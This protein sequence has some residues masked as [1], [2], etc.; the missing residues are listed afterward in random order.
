M[1][2]DRAAGARG[3]AASLATWAGYSGFEFV[4]GLADGTIRPPSMVETLP[5]TLL[6]PAEG[7][8]SLVAMPEARF[9]NLTNTITA[10]GS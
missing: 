6:P 4:A 7:K 2:M 3:G 10:V 5:F 1:T 8:V 9:C